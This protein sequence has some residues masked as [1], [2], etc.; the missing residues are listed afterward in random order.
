MSFLFLSVSI[1]YSLRV[2][3]I[4]GVRLQAS[5]TKELR[6]PCPHIFLTCKK[7]S[8]G[9]YLGKVSSDYLNLILTCEDIA[10]QLNYLICNIQKYT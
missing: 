10:I 7:T 2:S 4:C 1:G 8:K 5:K 6:R 3:F 9:L